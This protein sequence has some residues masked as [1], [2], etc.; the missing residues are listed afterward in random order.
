MFEFSS[1]RVRNWNDWCQYAEVRGE[2]GRK[3]HAPHPTILNVLLWQAISFK[4]RWLYLIHS[5][6]YLINYLMHSINYSMHSI[7]R[8]R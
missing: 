6:N 8:I 7:K 4:I 5:I 3:V 2:V 1:V